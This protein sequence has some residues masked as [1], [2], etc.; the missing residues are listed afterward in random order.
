MSNPSDPESDPAAGEGVG[1]VGEGDV[2][3]VGADAGEG[4]GE[5]EGEGD[6]LDTA[7]Q[8]DGDGVNGQDV[9]Q[10]DV[11]ASIDPGATDGDTVVAVTEPVPP[12]PP[13]PPSQ[14]R[15][16][17]SLNAVGGFVYRAM[18]SLLFIVGLIIAIAG[19]LAWLAFGAEAWG[20]ELFAVA[21][22][23]SVTSLLSGGQTGFL[24]RLYVG[25]DGRWSTSKLQVLLWTYAVVFA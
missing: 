21:A 10:P 14:A 9:G 16:A 12:A 6:G 5:A 15:L 4:V 24:R 1:A 23:F 11:V 17:D 18:N 2:P 19:L 7:V 22:L 25:V 8:G 13:T 20:A 3:D